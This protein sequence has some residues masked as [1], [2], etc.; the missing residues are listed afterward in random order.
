MR[1]RAEGRIMAGAVMMTV[2]FTKGFWEVMGG[3]V[4]GRT[5]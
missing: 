3:V 4:I 1:D 5:W 2:L